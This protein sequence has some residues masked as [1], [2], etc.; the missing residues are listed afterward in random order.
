M[1]EKLW[2]GEHYEKLETSGVLMNDMK[3]LNIDHHP[4][5]YLLIGYSLIQGLPH[6]FDSCLTIRY[7]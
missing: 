6:L 3:A 4:L 7:L 2:I 1:L 5:V